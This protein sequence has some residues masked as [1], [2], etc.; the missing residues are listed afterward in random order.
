MLGV[1]PKEPREEPPWIYQV[2]L[3]YNAARDECI[4][5]EE[6]NK[7]IPNFL[8]NLAGITTA[9]FVDTVVSIISLSP[10]YVI[11]ILFLL[12]IILIRKTINV[13]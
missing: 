4:K 13:K 1:D 11:Q 6:R 12:Y 2:G 5:K 10:A 8:R 7:E 3:L 9:P